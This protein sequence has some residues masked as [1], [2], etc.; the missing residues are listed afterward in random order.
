MCPGSFGFGGWFIYQMFWIAFIMGGGY[1]LYRL[2]K[3]TDKEPIRSGSYSTYRADDCPKCNAPVEAAFLR[4]PECGHKLKHNCPGCGK[5]VKTHWQVCA[6]CE[7][8][9][10]N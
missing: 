7:M 3:N 10:K 1:F 9:L 8:D 4:C 6:Y 2:I 5:I